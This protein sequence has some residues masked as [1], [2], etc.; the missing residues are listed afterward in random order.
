MKKNKNKQKASIFTMDCT[1]QSTVNGIKKATKQ[2][3]KTN[4]VK[5]KKKPYK[6]EKKTN[7]KN[8][9]NLK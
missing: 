2:K 4:W 1:L 8:K 9:K 7:K 3:K 6:G 5:R